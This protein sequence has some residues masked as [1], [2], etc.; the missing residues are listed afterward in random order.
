M[1]RS[2]FEK[3]QLLADSFALEFAKDI[4]RCVLGVPP[5]PRFLQCLTRY[6]LTLMSP[7]VIFIH[8]LHPISQS[9]TVY[10]LS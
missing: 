4:E 1:A 5:H 3:A 8:G 7:I 10:R 9:L 2:D 6:G